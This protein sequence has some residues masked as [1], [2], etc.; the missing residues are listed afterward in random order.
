METWRMEHLKGNWSIE[1][2]QEQEKKEKKVIISLKWIDISFIETFFPSPNYLALIRQQ[3]L[4][5]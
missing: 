3:H 2:E 4:R 5:T 1:E